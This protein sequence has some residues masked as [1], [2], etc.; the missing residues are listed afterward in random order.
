VI[1]ESAFID[2]RIQIR[3]SDPIRFGFVDLI[4]DLNSKDPTMVIIMNPNESLV[5]RRTLNKPESIPILGFGLANPYGVQKICFVDWFCPTV[6]KRFV[7]W[8]QFVGL[9]SKDWFLFI[10]SKI[11]NYSICSVS[12]GFVYDS[13]ILKNKAFKKVLGTY[14]SGLI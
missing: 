1:Q 13:C 2:L 14:Q 8:I 5:Q 10:R 6:F 11:P 4:C 12:E 3:E 7:L 9:F